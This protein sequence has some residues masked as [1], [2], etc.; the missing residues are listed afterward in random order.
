[1]NLS[2]ILIVILLFRAETKPTNRR[3]LKSAQP[4]L[5]YKWCN[6]C[7][8]IVQENSTKNILHNPYYFYADSII[9]LICTEVGTNLKNLTPPLVVLKQLYNIYDVLNHSRDGVI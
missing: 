3:L 6:L 1:M 8:K 9:C 2:G 5:S 7:L 4:Y